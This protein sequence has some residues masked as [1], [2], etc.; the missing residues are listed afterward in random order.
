MRWVGVLGEVK[1]GK[2]F[3]TGLIRT[4]ITGEK[5]SKSTMNGM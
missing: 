1:E 3:R 2:G 4:G 5:R